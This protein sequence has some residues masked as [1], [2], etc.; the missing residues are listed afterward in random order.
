ML[1]MKFPSRLRHQLTAL[2]TRV[3]IDHDVDRELRL[4]LELLTE[5]Y[6]RTGLSPDEARRAASLRFGGLTQIRERS[7][8]A[9]GVRLL[10]DSPDGTG[11]PLLERAAVR[12]HQR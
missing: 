11:G 4:H 5:E 3:G 12:D 8:D 2:F 9:V 1:A 6:Q 10:E 7:V